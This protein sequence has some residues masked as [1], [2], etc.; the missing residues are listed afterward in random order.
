MKKQ[1][2]RLA[3][4]RETLRALTPREAAEANGGVTT[5]CSDGGSSDCSYGTCVGCQHTLSPGCN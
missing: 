4:S 3:L 1:V 2:K 5:G